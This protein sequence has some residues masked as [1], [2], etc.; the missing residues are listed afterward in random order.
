MDFLLI[1]IE[2]LASFISPCVLPML[3]MYISYFAGQDKSKNKTI[4]NSIGFVLGFSFVF[5]LLG[6]FASTFGRIVNFYSNYINI[7]VGIIIILFGLHYAGILNINVLNKTKGIKYSNKDLSFIT[8]ALFGMFFSITWTPCVGVFLSSALMMSATQ[9]SIIQG[10][11][12][13][14]LY[15]LGLGIPFIITAIFLE[16]LKST[17]DF[18]KQHYNIINKISGII[19]IISGL[20]IIFR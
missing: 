2:G 16:K 12:M 20:I 4:I 8:S 9:G 5:I 6:V 13:L 7:I 1:F 19:L 10:L 18:I 11:L 14:V 17:F 3:P 15:S